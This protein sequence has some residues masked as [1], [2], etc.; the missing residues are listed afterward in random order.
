MNKQKRLT[1][2]LKIITLTFCVIV[3]FVGSFL[4]IFFIFYPVKYKNIIFE[5]CDKYQVNYALAFAVINTESGFVATKTSSKGAMGLMQIMP[6]TAVFIADQLCYENFSVESLYSPEINIQFGVYYLSYLSKKF[7]DLEQVICAYNAGETAVRGWL[8][9]KEYSFD[10][11]KL[12]TIPYQETSEYLK[13]VQ[14]NMKIYEKI[15][16]K[17]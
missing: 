9:N 15:V 3:L 17:F 11:N 8:N 6:R 7:D 16:Q 5:N 12:Q 14:K 4:C 13:K 1:N 10:G 2:I